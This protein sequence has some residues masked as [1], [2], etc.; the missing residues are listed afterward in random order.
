MGLIAVERGV[1]LLCERERRHGGSGVVEV[2]R[3]GR[4]GGAGT[5]AAALRYT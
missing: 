2:E 3:E 1:R 4:C 5:A